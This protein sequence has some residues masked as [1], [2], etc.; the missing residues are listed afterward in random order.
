M[1]AKTRS[2]IYI[3]FFII[4]LLFL[5]FNDRKNSIKS[6]DNASKPLILVNGKIPPKLSKIEG[7][8]TFIDE[9]NCLQCHSSNNDR[10]D[11]APEIPHI[12]R[13]N[14]NSC[15]LIER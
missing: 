5:L 7:H 3:G 10:S 14:C 1:I 11:N 15:H 4:F 8:L 13:E 2:I 9:K 6:I 12:F